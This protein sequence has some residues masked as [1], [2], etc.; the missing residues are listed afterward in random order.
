MTLTDLEAWRAH[1][2]YSIRRACVVLDIS[3]DRWK[4]MAS[5]GRIPA[6][7]GLACAALAFGLPEWRKG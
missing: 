6:H 3:Q 4:R 5:G 7:I 2:G 1:M